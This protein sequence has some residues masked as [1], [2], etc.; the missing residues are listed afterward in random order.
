MTKNVLRR[1]RDASPMGRALMVA[2]VFAFVAGVT[3]LS[4]GI[5]SVLDDDGPV[6]SNVPRLDDNVDLNL[7]T[8][9]TPTRAPTDP[10]TAT[11][12]PTPQSEPP[13]PEDGYRLVIDKLSINSPVDTY[14]LDENA[15]P[16]VPTGADA[17]EVVAW[18]NFSARP[19]TGGNAVFAGHNSWYGEAVF[20]YIH[21]L[22]QGDAIK[23]VDS[24]GV[25]L[26]YTVSS[27]FSVDPEDPAS[28]EVMRPTQTDVV[29]LI[30]CGGSFVDTDD[31]VFG[32]E[33]TDRV[34]VRADLASVSEAAVSTGS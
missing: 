31:P 24:E 28:L 15:I 11:I 7:R 26:V 8:S 12:A 21:Q 4:V 34:I 3:L 2:G 13:L 33:F 5:V 1:L 25:E 22:E 17:A 9:P 18:Y 10:P 30:T 27:V 23:L 32:G 14:G 16:V 19:G 20:T 6:E 29:T